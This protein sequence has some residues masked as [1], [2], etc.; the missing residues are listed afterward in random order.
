MPPVDMPLSPPPTGAGYTVRDLC[1]RWKVG[2][3]KIRTFIRRG[4]LIAVNMATNLSGKPQWRITPESVSAF[5]N[6]R[7]SAPPPQPARRRK[8]TPAVDYYP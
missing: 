1:R 4:D 6:R 3:D 7:T 5:E 2:A 8:R